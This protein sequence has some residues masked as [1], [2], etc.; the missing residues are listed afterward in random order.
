MSTATISGL[1]HAIGSSGHLILRVRSTDIRLRGVDGGSVRIRARGAAVLHGVEVEPGD[2]QVTITVRSGR[3]P[4]LEIDVPIAAAVMVEGASAD[5]QAHGLYGEQRYRS[6]SG[7]L[8]LDGVRGSITAEAMSGDVDIVADGPASILARTVSGE[9][10]I[11]AG[12]LD[13]LRAITTSG[14]VR[15]AAR[16]AGPGPFGIETVSGDVLLAPAGGVRVMATTITGDV[17]SDLPSRFE[18]TRGQGSLVIDEGG[19]TMTFRSM[20]GDL[21]VVRAVH[22]SPAP[23]LSSAPVP[24]GVPDEGVPDAVEARRA[25][26]ASAAASAADPGRPAVDAIDRAR[27]DIL[28]ALERGDIDIDQAGRRLEALD[29]PANH[30]ETDRG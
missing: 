3:A 23:A 1:E 11:Q 10:S 20:S 21:R 9:L 6:A 25:D 24:E 18:G 26:D 22:R 28:R 7:D 15:V 27:L 14:D 5:I 4:H 13:A 8:R 16:F 29:E 30:L 17:R 12:I 2:D 19:A